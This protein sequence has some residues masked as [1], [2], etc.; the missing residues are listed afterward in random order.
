MSWHAI[1]VVSG[2]ARDQRNGPCAALGPSDDG[3][4]VVIDQPEILQQIAGMLR[5]RGIPHALSLGVAGPDGW[6]HILPTPRAKSNCDYTRSCLVVL[7]TLLQVFVPKA[8][9]NHCSGAAKA[10]PAALVDIQDQ[11]QVCAGF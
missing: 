2:A 11:L 6:V 7:L 9:V 1:S 5:D 10:A 8:Q 4:G 3:G